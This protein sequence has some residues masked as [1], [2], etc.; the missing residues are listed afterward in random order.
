[1]RLGDI[2][3]LSRKTVAMDDDH[4]CNPTGWHWRGALLAFC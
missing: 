3:V 1:M 4:H 2:M